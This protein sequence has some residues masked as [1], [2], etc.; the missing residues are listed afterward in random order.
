MLAAAASSSRTFASLL[1]GLGPTPQQPQ[2]MI[3]RFSA[4][5]DSDTVFSHAL[6]ASVTRTPPAPQ[7]ASC[8]EFA[9]RNLRKRGLEVW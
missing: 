8:L 3:M 6:L 4:C 7:S 1:H 5:D 9:S 2:L